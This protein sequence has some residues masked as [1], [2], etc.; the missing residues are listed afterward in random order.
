[1]FKG[2]LIICLLYSLKKVV[3][4][5]ALS[6]GNEYIK[7]YFEKKKKVLDNNIQQPTYIIK[8]PK[9]SNNYYGNNPELPK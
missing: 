4:P 8:N 3:L 2:F 7:F 9:I 6:F 1:M 5:L